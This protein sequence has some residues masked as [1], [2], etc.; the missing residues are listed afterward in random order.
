MWS[1]LMMNLNNIIMPQ[2]LHWRC[3]GRVAAEEQ[4]QQGQWDLLQGDSGVGTPVMGLGKQHSTRELIF[5]WCL[6][7]S[8]ND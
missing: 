8:I 4:V 3:Y 1:L 2:I 7:I 5:R 6:V